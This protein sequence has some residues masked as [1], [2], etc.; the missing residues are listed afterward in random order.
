MSKPAFNMD[1]TMEALREGNDL[2]GEVGNSYKDIRTHC[3]CRTS[4]GWSTFWH[5]VRLNE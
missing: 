3:R 2:S 5:G 4:G 1:A